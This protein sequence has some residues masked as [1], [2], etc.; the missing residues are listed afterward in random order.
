MK[1]IIFSLFLFITIQLNA[2][3]SLSGGVGILNGVGTSRK[4]FGFN[5]G[6]EFPRSSD[7]TFF[8]RGSFFPKITDTTANYA[9]MTAIS[10][11]TT[12][13]TLTIPYYL[14]CHSFYIEG[15]TRSYMLNDYDNGFALYGGSVFGF[16]VNTT[17]AKFDKFDYTNQYEWEGKYTLPNQNPTKGS[18][19]YLALGIQGGMKYTI[20]IKGTLFFDITGTYSVLD[21]ANNDAGLRSFTYSP[22]NFLFQFGYRKDLY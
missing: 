11:T 13:T 17:T 15:G 16:G 20:P 22:L 12:P 8:V 7:L 6:F 19:Y 14:R 9:N 1:T 10:P 4:P 2:Q 5:L 18:I 21:L 3:V